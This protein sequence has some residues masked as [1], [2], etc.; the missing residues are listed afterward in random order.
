[1]LVGIFNYHGHILTRPQLNFFGPFEYWDPHKLAVLNN[2]NLSEII[3][4]KFLGRGMPH[5]ILLREIGGFLVMIF[6]FG[7]VPLIMAKTICKDVYQRL[8][9][10]RYS[11]FI[12]LVLLALSLP[13]KM[14]LRWAFNIKYIIAIPEFFFNI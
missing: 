14:G 13:I 12:V 8:G 11:I 5:N 9:V 2:V 6:Y 7:L 4:M 3:Y 1:M 10:L